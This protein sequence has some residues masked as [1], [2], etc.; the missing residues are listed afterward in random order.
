M[1]EV[2]RFLVARGNGDGG[3][4]SYWLSLGLEYGIHAVKILYG[5]VVKSTLVS[6]ERRISRCKR[7]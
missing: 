1:M 7:R 4:G 5:S 6:H 2:E 3:N